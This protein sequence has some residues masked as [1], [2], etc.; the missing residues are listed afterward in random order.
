[1][2]LDRPLPRK[3][4][5]DRKTVSVASLLNGQKPPTDSGNHLGF[6][7]DDPTL[8]IARRQIRNR[9]RTPIGPDDV[10]NA[11]PHLLFVHGTLYTLFDA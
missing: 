7:P 9:Q 6:P 3:Q 1:M 8:C 11:R 5:V 4:F 10:A 2:P